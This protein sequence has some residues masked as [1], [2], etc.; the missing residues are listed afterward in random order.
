MTRNCLVFLGLITCF[1]AFC[2]KE[3]NIW[4]FGDKAG[5]DFNANDPFP[6][7]DGEMNAIAGCAVISDPNSGELLFYS[8]GEAVWNRNHIIMPGGANLTGDKTATQ[9]ALIVPAPG[10]SNLYYLFSVSSA[11]ITNGIFSQIHYSIINMDLNGGLGDIIDSTKNTFLVGNVTEKLTAVP[12]ANGEDYWLITHEVNSNGFFLFE[13]TA[14]GI[15]EPISQH[16]GS[17]HNVDSGSPE[18]AGYLKASPD[19]SMLAAAVTSA[20]YFRPFDLF[21]FNNA[22][23]VLSNYR[24]LGNFDVQ[25]GVSFSPDNTKLYLSGISESFDDADFLYQFDLNAEDIASSRVGLDKNFGRLAAYALQLAPN[26]KI[27]GAGAP[28]TSFEE[29]NTWHGMVVIEKPN[30]EGLDCG[31]K[32]TQF[33]FGEGRVQNGLPNFIENV[34]NNLTDR[35]N[36]NVPCSK[37]TLLSIIPN[38]AN[39]YLQLQIPERCFEQQGLLNIYNALGQSLARYM[40]NDNVFSIE[41]SHLA[42]GIYF[43]ALYMPKY[44]IVKKFMKE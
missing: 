20:G 29:N 21:D 33:N 7:T 42:S 5:L 43:A 18:F 35:H 6:L 25:Y 34:F 37:N 17:A 2:Q 11:D 19:G 16:I 40:V 15:S 27:Y 23:G 22:T 3:A 4:Y 13:I 36:P 12:H 8:N 30:E 26:G 38:P 31:Y 10:R 44:K 24:T 39:D 14:E 32:L 9:A 28:S 41:V 1:P